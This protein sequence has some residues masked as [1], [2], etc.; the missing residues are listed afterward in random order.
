MHDARHEASEPQLPASAPHLDRRRFLQL[1][2]SSLALMGLAGCA[3]Q[4]AKRIVPYVKDPEGQVPGKPLFFASA[5]TL[6]G[7]ARGVLI[8]CHMGRPTKI[9]GNP[10]HP[11]SR[12]GSDP[13]MQAAILD[14][15]DPDRSQTVSRG[16][17]L[18]TWEA[19]ASAARDRLAAQQAHR[20]AGLRLLSETI[21]SPTLLGLIAEFLHRFPEARWVVHEPLQSASVQ[22]GAQLAFGMPLDVH[23]RLDR[24]ETVLALD[25]DLFFADAAGIRNAREFIVRRRHARNRLYV[26]EPTPSNT[27]AMADHRQPVS[28]R[29][30]PE[31]TR[32]IAQA[33]GLPVGG[34]DT[35]GLFARYPGLEPWVAAVSRDLSSQ[36]GRGVVAAG[37]TQPPE[38]HALA[39]ALNHALGNVNQSVYY[40]DPVAPATGPQRSD[41]ATLT[42]EMHAGRVDTL[43]ILGGNPVYTAPGDLDVAGALARVPHSFRLGLY[44][45]ETSRR[46]TWHLPE[47][48]PLEA[49]GD[50][51]AADGTVTI[52][53]PGIAP[54]YQGRS[55][56]EVMSLLL[57]GRGTDGES[58]LRRY[59]QAARP[60]AAQPEA[61]FEAFWE[62]AL[63]LGI[64]SGSAAAIRNVTPRANLAGSL[65]SAAA[66]QA[67]LE[68]V[69]RPDPTVWDGRFGNNAWLQELPKPFSKLTWD[70]VAYVA[71]ETA[72]RL[73]VENGDEVRLALGDRSVLA[74]VWIL[75]GQAVDTVTVTLGYGRDFGG[76][77]KG[78]GF[79]AYRLRTSASSWQASGLVVEKTGGKV[80][81]ATTQ[82][83]QRMEGLDL[84]QVKSVKEVE[85]LPPGSRLGKANPPLSLYPE[86]H[87]EGY[88]W[89]MA[90]DLTACIGCNACVVACQAENNIPVVGKEEVLRNRQMHWLRIDRYDL[91]DL[92]N[93]GMVFQPVPCMHCEKA[94]C[95]LVCPTE[96][97]VHGKEGLN[98]MVYNR[99]IGTR[100][101][102]NNCPYKVRRFNFYPYA[103][104]KTESLK[105]MRNPEVSVRSRGVMEKCTYCIQRIEAAREDATHE[106][107][108]IRDGEV[109]TACQS[110][111]PT[112]AIVFGDM[113]DPESEV[114][115]WKASPLSYG[116]LEE[117]NTRPRTTYLARVQ[118]PNPELG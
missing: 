19:F 46:C 67:E 81:L 27:G 56:L 59:W 12:G 118:N 52:M 44:E 20:G 31:V 55:A 79:D 15:Y 76:V 60:E 114:S 25:A 42:A 83:E 95:E 30:V 105:A 82:H 68:L 43:L 69:I 94:P 26:A 17:A 47:T 115:R 91:G 39:H 100:Y 8:E 102:S 48:H 63:N 88:A 65:P 106:G 98:E 90:I 99:C 78:A 109:R 89:A 62:K 77:A 54:L 117:L 71:P 93:P 104:W 92:A 7:L 87:S 14:L 49:W 28:A 85:G 45:D 57:D 51:R 75:P 24:A 6:G 3:P 1:M 112:K 74:P 80:P 29:D 101:C 41:L 53:Q 113:N 97:T 4:A 96:A 35:T 32:A 66:P 36:R 38:V 116:L 72:R 18:S 11:I 58:L 2:G 103:D 110:A 64:V 84:V 40:S 5:L 16:G 21:T 111:C 13:F 34:G 9:E 70:N 22:V 107:R 23:Y 50:A 37:P 73:G 33:L 61:G 10:D 108:P 86:P